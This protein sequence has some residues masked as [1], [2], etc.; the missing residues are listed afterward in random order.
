LAWRN[1]ALTFSEIWYVCFQAEET[2]CF[3]VGV[4]EMAINIETESL[5]TLAE[6]SAMLPGRPSMCAIWRWR[7]KGVRGRRLETVVIGGRP[8]TS[9]EALA[10]FARQQGGA[11]A[12]PKVRTPKQRERAIRA[13]E[14]ELSQGSVEHERRAR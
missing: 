7:M 5:L 6:A 14:R 9:R 13:A 2:F 4:Y 1:F 10:R 12:V 8:Y 3:T 11:D